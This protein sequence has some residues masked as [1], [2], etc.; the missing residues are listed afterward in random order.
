M[1][2]VG[3]YGA[4]FVEIYKIFVMLNITIWQSTKMPLKCDPGDS[5]VEIAF[6]IYILL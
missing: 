6:Y 5:I 4:G 1:F 3:H 2:H